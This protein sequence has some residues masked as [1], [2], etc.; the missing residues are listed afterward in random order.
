MA[1]FS[2][3][4]VMAGTGDTE[5]FVTL[6]RIRKILEI[7]MKYGFTM[8][9]HMAIGFLF[10]GSGKYTFSTSNLSI[11]SLLIALY[12]VF[13][14]TTDENNKYHLEALRHF[15]VLAIESRLL[16]AVDIENGEFVPVPLQID[17]KSNS[18]ANQFVDAARTTQEV[19]TPVMLEDLHKIIRIRVSDPQYYSVVIEKPSGTLQ[20]SNGSKS[21]FARCSKLEDQPQ[22]YQK[23]ISKMSSL[24]PYDNEMISK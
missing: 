14:E 16:Q 17:Y 18:K 24:L 5:C 13:P 7:D 8:A 22:F 21:V 11:A 12:P 3:S 6:R 10:L 20:L 2:I 23:S 4:M 15:Y 1:A 19:K 9:I